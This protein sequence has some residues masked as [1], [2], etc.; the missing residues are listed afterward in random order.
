[1]AVEF[2]DFPFVNEQATSTTPLM[3]L[4]TGFVVG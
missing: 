1:M 2:V 3:L 4:M